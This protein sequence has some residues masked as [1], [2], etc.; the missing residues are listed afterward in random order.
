LAASVL[1]VIPVI[2]VALPFVSAAVLAMVASWRIA[3]W[4]NAG[5]A[6]L[7]FV[8]AFA[9]AWQV[10]TAA[11]HLAV[12]T[13][14]VAMTTSWFGRRD[15]AVSLAARSLNRQRI[16]RYHVGYQALIGAIQAAALADDLIVTW[17]ALVVAVA[18]SAAVTGAA[19][20][21][22]A[23]AAAS[24]LVQHCAIGLLLAL[25]GTLL[26]DLAPGAAGVFLLLG[27]GTVAG[28][29]PLHSWQPNTAAEGVPPGAIVVAVLANVPLM[30]F[31][32][33]HIVPELLIGFGLVSLL[34]CAV[35]LFAR[36][37]RRRTVALAGMAQLGMVVFAI[38][39]GAKQVAWLHMT[40]LTLTRSTVLQ[41]QGEDT[42]AWLA[43]ALMPL[44]ALYL[45]ASPTVA[46]DPWLLVPLAAGVLLTVSAL[47]GRCPGGMR[48]YPVAATPIWLQLVLVMLLGF[49]M[50]SQVAAWFSEVAAG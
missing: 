15:I 29:V 36:L 43:L 1:G 28:L 20:G 24:T 4:F 35:A 12:L 14:F 44:Y 39:L 42:I 18:A 50:P 2:V 22:A 10:P 38:G 9:L 11:T 26:L 13:A 40:L 41:S 46:V 37:D 33:L 27:Y 21:A 34:P 32:R 30:L 47:L 5:S 49:A 19:R 25:L 17:I 8:V 7:Q 31:M 6:S 23:A 48:A 16:R 3:I 45:L